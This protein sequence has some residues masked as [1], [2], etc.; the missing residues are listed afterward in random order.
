MAFQEKWPL[1][2]AKP[3][4]G[5]SGS[6]LTLTPGGSKRGQRRRRRRREVAGKE[7]VRE[8]GGVGMEGRSCNLQPRNLH[9]YE[10][11]FSGPT[12]SAT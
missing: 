4:A 11:M 6:S 10:T 5:V 9:S 12:F 8:G 7:K 2:E 3:G 1:P